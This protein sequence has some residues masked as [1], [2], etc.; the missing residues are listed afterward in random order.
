MLNV[1]YMYM[2]FVSLRVWN[3]HVKDV[4]SRN[5]VGISC[6]GPVVDGHLCGR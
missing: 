2:F 1:V 4:H 5:A 6:L 3:V